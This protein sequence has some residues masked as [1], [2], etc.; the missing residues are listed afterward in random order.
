MFTRRNFI[1]HGNSWERR[2]RPLWPS[3]EV[4][5]DS[6][7]DAI[8]LGKRPRDKFKCWQNNHQFQACSSKSI[9]DHVVSSSC[10]DFAFW[11]QRSLAQYTMLSRLWEFGSLWVFLCTGY[12]LANWF[13]KQDLNI[14]LPISQWPLKDWR[15]GSIRRIK[16]SKYLLVWREVTVF[17][18]DSNNLLLQGGRKVTAIPG[19]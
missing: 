10:E 9:L 8:S 15:E 6:N 18:C 11:L 13:G 17:T 5:L 16:K 4:F 3:I 12:S 19:V 2:Q 1:R 7:W 14:F